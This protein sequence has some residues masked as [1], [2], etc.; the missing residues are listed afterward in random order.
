MVTRTMG[1][2]LGVTTRK[3][4][5]LLMNCNCGF[6][7]V[8]CSLNHR[9]PVVGYNGRRFLNELQLWEHERLLHGST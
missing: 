9:A 5:T 3:T 4:T 6:S 1:M 2:S 7:A 8:F